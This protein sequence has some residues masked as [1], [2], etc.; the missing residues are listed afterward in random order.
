MWLSVGGK[1]LLSYYTFV[2]Y[3]HR[4]VAN[5][6]TCFAP[7]I[8]GGMCT[9]PSLDGVR[10]PACQYAVRRQT[11]TTS[12]SVMRKALPS[13]RRQI[14]RCS[15]RSYDNMYLIQNPAG[16]NDMDGVQVEHVLQQVPHIPFLL[17]TNRRYLRRY[18]YRNGVKWRKV[19]WRII[20]AYTY[21]DVSYLWLTS[22]AAVTG[23]QRQG[24]SSN[25]LELL[26][27]SKIFYDQ[28]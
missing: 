14:L 25:F 1:L 3:D 22:M 9:V 23:A 24:I 27:P 11:W 17:Y 4:S 6:D 21:C 26:Y 7:N 16:N 28:S 2:P 10:W 15:W 19:V 20:D 12:S 8:L 13:S 5:T 18:I